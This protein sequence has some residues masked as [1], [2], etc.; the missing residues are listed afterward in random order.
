MEVVTREMGMRRL[1]QLA[2]ILD[3]AKPHREGIWPIAGYHQRAFLWDCNT[4]ACALGHWAVNNQ[5]RWETDGGSVPWLKAGRKFD[6]H[7]GAEH[8]FCLTYLESRELFAGNGCGFAENNP[9]K[10]AQYIRDF[11]ARNCPTPEIK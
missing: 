5:D 7:D 4:P 9:K 8:D 10:A 11:V 1:L 2:E 3:K 6:P